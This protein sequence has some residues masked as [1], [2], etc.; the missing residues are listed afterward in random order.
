MA[1]EQ[2]VPYSRFKEV[3]EERQALKTHAME[4]EQQLADRG[5]EDIDVRAAVAPLVK[6]QVD[7]TVMDLNQRINELSTRLE[8]AESH[9]S[10]DKIKGYLEG[11]NQDYTETVAKVDEYWHKLPQTTRTALESSQ[12]GKR[13]DLFMAVYKALQVSEASVESKTE[14]LAQVRTVVTNR[15]ATAPATKEVDFANMTTEQ[16]W[17]YHKKLRG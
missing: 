3:N 2:S 8:M 1:D 13:D 7:T 9:R 12:K 4:L 14:A 6:Q 10:I 16:F 17:E 5:G 15:R 11:K